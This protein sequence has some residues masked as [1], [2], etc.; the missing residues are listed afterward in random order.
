MWELKAYIRIFRHWLWL[1]VLGAALGA[2]AAYFVLTNMGL[3]PQYEA[4][5]TVTVGAQVEATTVSSEELSIGQDLV[6]NYVVLAKRPPITDAIIT[7]LGLDISTGELVSRHLDVIQEGQTRVVLITG[8]DKDPVVAAAIANEAARQMRASGPIRPMELI[9][10]VSLAKVPTDGSTEPL[11]IIVLAGLAGFF[12]AAI[13]AILIELVRDRPRTVNWAASR[14]D[15]PILGTFK[16]KRRLSALRRLAGGNKN[17]GTWGPPEPVWWAVMDA[18]KR[19]AEEKGLGPAARPVLAIVSPDKSNRRTRAFAS[20]EL[21][22][23]WASTGDDVI[24]VDADLEETTIEKWFQAPSDAGISTLLSE[25]G[26][27]GLDRVLL[28]SGIENLAVVGSGSKPA[29]SSLLYRQQPWQKA[30]AQLADKARAIIVNSPDVQSGPE[31]MVT[32][33]N[34][35]GVLF[36]IDLGKTSAAE[37]NDALELMTMSGRSVLGAVVNDY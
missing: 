13:L 14:I 4:T 8:K 35:S 16:M 33:A 19:M 3:M 25:N 31:A 9:Q 7:N 28:Q 21:A 34:A 27:T 2:A 22:R 6:P 30:I 29:N 20:L 10:I 23:A 37:A 11:M 1:L 15:M 36:V 18:Y 5:A 24:L 32:T 12:A 26:R 17:P